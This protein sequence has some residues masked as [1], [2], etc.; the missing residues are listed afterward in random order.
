VAGGKDWAE[1][2]SF[3]RLISLITG[4]A[5]T[6]GKKRK[7]ET[8]IERNYPYCYLLPGGLRRFILDYREDKIPRGGGKGIFEA[9]DERGGH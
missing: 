8:R 3:Y 6:L 1:D 7:R 4:D 9:R 5:I 2:D